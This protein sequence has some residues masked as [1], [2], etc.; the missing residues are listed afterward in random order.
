MSDNT[1]STDIF[2]VP[3]RARAWRTRRFGDGAGPFGIMSKATEEIG[4]V[5]RALVGEMEGR[6]GRGD[7]VQE[8]A[9]TIIVLASL[10]A[11]RH[12]DRNVFQA[13]LDE[14]ARL[15]A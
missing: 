12:P 10:C 14:M 8:A 15:G 13:V 6:E 4:E 11:L 7:L 1:D 2:T 3:E 5:A 9:Q